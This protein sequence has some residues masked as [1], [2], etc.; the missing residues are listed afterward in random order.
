M[1]KENTAK[2]IID[3][4]TNNTATSSQDS[5]SES[6]SNQVEEPDKTKDL[7]MSTQQFKKKSVCN[8]K[9]GVN[10]NTD[11]DDPGDTIIQQ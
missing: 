3:D 1:S 7:S 10:F 9:K 5:T 4:N 2:E 8:A 6:S 11:L